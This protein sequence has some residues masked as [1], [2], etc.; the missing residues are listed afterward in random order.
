LEE[1]LAECDRA[2]DEDD[3]F[4]AA[5]VQRAYTHVELG[6][7][8]DALEDASD[9]IK[10]NRDLTSAYLVRMRARLG[11]GQHNQAVQDVDDAAQGS[12]DP[13]ETFALGEAYGR[14]AVGRR[15]VIR[16]GSL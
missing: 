13:E 9:A 2:I 10:L 5:Y 16:P 1:A 12:L 4:A 7:F 3:K 14:W 11:L 8:R 6:R 15:P